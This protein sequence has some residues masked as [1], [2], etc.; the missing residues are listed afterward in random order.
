[1]TILTTTQKVFIANACQQGSTRTRIAKALG[2]S[3]KTLVLL[4]A[5]D[6]GLS[7][8]LRRLPS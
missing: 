2:V 8:A 4:V 1:M 3:E 6:P 5:H 7:E